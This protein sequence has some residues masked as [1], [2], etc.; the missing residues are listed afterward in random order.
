MKLNP[1]VDCNHEWRIYG[2]RLEEEVWNPI[3]SNCDWLICNKC[4]ENKPTVD[5]SNYKIIERRPHPTSRF[6]TGYRM[7]DDIIVEI[8]N[9]EPNN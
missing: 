7:F 1:K 4:G 9:H 5:R 6:P 3:G 8:V 2:S